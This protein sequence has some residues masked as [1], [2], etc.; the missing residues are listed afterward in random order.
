MLLSLTP[1]VGL[2]GCFP[3][4]VNQMFSQFSIN[5][6]LWLNVYSILKFFKF[7]PIGVG[8]FV[9]STHSFINLASSIVCHVLTHINSRVVSNENI[10]I[11]LT[12]LLH[13]LLKVM[14][15]KGSGM[16]LVKHRVI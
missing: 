9:L 6:F 10:A 11:L 12:Q 14:F 1:L 15:P 8:N 7:K 3:F 16:R 13:C 4:N 2:L 5:L